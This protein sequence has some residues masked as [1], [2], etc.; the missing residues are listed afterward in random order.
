L[1]NFDHTSDLDKPISTA[2]QNAL[3][4]KMTT[5][6]SIALGGANITDYTLVMRNLGLVASGNLTLDGTYLTRNNLIATYTICARTIK[7]S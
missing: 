7:I 4:T 5:G 1:G 6:G 2:V 3:N